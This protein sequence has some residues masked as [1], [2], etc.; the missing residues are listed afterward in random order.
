MGQTQANQGVTSFP[1]P[2]FHEL[3]DLDLVGEKQKDTCCRGLDV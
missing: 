3:P 2:D 1:Q